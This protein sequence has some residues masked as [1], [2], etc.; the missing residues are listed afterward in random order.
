MQNGVLHGYMYD[1]S[2]S[3]TLKGWRPLSFGTK[4]KHCVVVVMEGKNDRFF[5]LYIKL[6]SNF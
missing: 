4:L 1:V 6:V 5:F 3:S 2:D